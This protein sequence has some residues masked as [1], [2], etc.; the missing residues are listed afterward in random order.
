MAA[1]STLLCRCQLFDLC[2]RQLKIVIALKMPQPP[3]QT[4]LGLSRIPPHERL[5]NG[6][7]TS[8]PCWWR[9]FWKTQ[10][11]PVKQIANNKLCNNR[12]RHPRSILHETIHNSYSSYIWY[13]VIHFYGRNSSTKRFSDLD[14]R[15]TL[16]LPY[17]RWVAS[18]SKQP[19]TRN[20]PN[21]RRWQAIF[22]PFNGN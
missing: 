22:V 18:S 14:L 12:S 6:P 7:A 21:L 20:L 11:V 19:A 1:S 9:L 8:V 16:M 5:L 17:F 4:F 15:S 2:K 13:S 3:T 10:S